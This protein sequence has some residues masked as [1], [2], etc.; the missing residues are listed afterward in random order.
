MP[1]KDEK[2]QNFRLVPARIKKVGA[3]F[4]LKET[5]SEAKKYQFCATSF[6]NKKREIGKPELAFAALLEKLDFNCDLC[7]P[8]WLN[9]LQETGPDFGR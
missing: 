3:S 7:R 9:K 4:E 5:P 1:I 2:L 6:G 8:T